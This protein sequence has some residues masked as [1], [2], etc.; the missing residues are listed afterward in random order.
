MLL[1]QGI[2]SLG[3]TPPV[4]NFH[5]KHD[6]IFKLVLLGTIIVVKLIKYSMLL[7][8]NSTIV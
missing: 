5:E 3:I 1:L 8:G 2:F 7:T 4:I 6:Y